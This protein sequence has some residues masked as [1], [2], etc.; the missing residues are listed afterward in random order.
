MYLQIN[1]VSKAFTQQA[2]LKDISFGVQEGSL[3]ALLG[4]SGSGKTTL[5]RIL[6]GLETATGGHVQIAGQTIDQVPPQSRQIGFVF[7]NYALFRYLTVAQNIAFGLQTQRRP[8]REIKERVTELLTLTGLTPL[9]DRYPDQLSGGQKQ[10][11]AFA[12]AIAPE[13]KVLFLDEPFAALDKQIRQEL[14]GWLKQLIHKIGITSIFVTHDHEEAIET[15]DEIVVMSD[16]EIKQIGTPTEIYNQPNCQFVA[17]FIGH[18]STLKSPKLAGFTLPTTP[19]LAHIRPERVHVY[20]KSE[21]AHQSGALQEAVVKNVTFKGATTTVELA[22]GNQSLLAN[23]SVL[24]PN[25]VIGETVSVLIEQLTI[26]HDGINQLVYNRAPAEKKLRTL[27][28]L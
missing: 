26:F 25:L 18:S 20:K 11:V 27:A 24:Q 8:K 1:H 10:R 13:P 6:A 23:R 5:L 21:Q 19:F 3:T 7:Q 15:A 12:R 28:S 16:G 2:V 9:A 17:E 22:L 4:P 14:R